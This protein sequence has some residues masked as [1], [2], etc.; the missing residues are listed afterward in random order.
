MFSASSQ[1]SLIAVLRSYSELLHSNGQDID[2]HDLAWTLRQRRSALSW[3]GYIAASS[4]GELCSKISAKMEGDESSVS[5][6]ALPG[7]QKRVLGIFT[8]Q[9][10]QYVR[11]GAELIQCS[12]AAR[13]IIEGSESHLRELRGGDAPTWSLTAELLAKS[14]SRV[15]E[16]AISQPLCTAIQILLV[17]LFRLGGVCFDVVVGHS[18]G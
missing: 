5:I 9:G 7:P 10:A 11:M 12:E 13:I 17:D 3:R 8:G 4:L 1:S 18:S 16:A 14:S 15:H 2:L 6:K